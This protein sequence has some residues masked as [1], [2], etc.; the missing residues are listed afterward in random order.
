[1]PAD[2][3]QYL[4]NKF[5]ELGSEAL[6]RKRI[7]LD[8]NFW[9]L[10]RDQKLGRR[11]NDE[12]GALLV[13]L[14]CLV[15]SGRVLCLYSEHTLSELMKHAS[16]SIREE[17]AVLM[18]ELSAGICVAN[19]DR[20]L[21]NELIFF[22][23]S[24]LA[25]TMDRWE[26]SRL[27]WTKPF[28]IHLDYCPPKFAGLA[29]DDAYRLQIGFIEHVWSMTISEV[30][31][32]INARDEPYPSLSWPIAAAIN[33]N[34]EVRKFDHENNSLKDFYLSELNG[35]LDFLQ[36]K[37]AIRYA[38]FSERYNVGLRPTTERE[39]EI[40]G[41]LLRR[42]AMTLARKERLKEMIPGAY[43]KS[44]LHATVRFD[45]GRKF[46]A[47]DL[48]DFQHAEVALPYCDYFL[49][50]KPHAHLIRSAKLDK[51]FSCIVCD[52]PREALAVLSGTK[53]EVAN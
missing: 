21:D 32:Q 42:A 31:A 53:G 11:V 48:I 52:S 19:H 33:I 1:M 36:P 47:N 51:D 37:M 2:I 44:M 28:F 49:T 38:E 5:V 23:G 14:K 29:D 16:H 25:P 15:S 8:T 20:L 24:L 46:K 30:I 7:Y 9:S 13:C 26:L 22:V 45:R 43:I 41:V 10:L 18:D 12:V 34:S 4:E 50:D 40:C 35:W 3:W 6:A 17:T 27:A 39:L